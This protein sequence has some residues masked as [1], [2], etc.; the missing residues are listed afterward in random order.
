MRTLATPAPRIVAYDVMV[1]LLYP[2][3]ARPGQVVVALWHSTFPPYVTNR[4]SA[5]ILRYGASDFPAI[6][7]LIADGVLV[8]RTRPIPPH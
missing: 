8:P 2:V 7:Q 5:R 1:P 6:A 4:G 3:R